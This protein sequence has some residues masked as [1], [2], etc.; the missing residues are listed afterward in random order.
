MSGD[1]Q[2]SDVGTALPEPLV[3]RAVD[4]GGRPVPEVAILF[5]L[6]E[7]D[8]RLTGADDATASA[9]YSTATGASGEAWSELMLGSEPGEHRVL[10]TAT[11]FDQAVEFHAT[12]LAPAEPV[13]SGDYALRF[14][15]AQGQEVLLPVV[16]TPGDQYTVEAWV[17][18]AASAAYQSVVGNN[19]NATDA[20]GSLDMVGGRLRMIITPRGGAIHE[21]RGVTVLPLGIWIHVAGVYDGAHMRLYVNGELDGELPLRGPITSD[22]LGRGTVIGGYAGWNSDE[23]SGWMTGLID[24]VR[25]WEVARTPEQLMADMRRPVEAQ[26]GLIGYWPLDDGQ[27]L[28]A[29][30]RSGRGQDGTLGNHRGSGR[31][32]W[33]PGVFHELGSL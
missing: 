15:G 32:Q 21:L 16:A 26:P 8:G 33:V 27:G 30:D 9:I 24:E 10:A 20:K 1:G 28:V 13:E 11:G 4:P 31:P 12:A 17:N 6:I 5:Q 23:G 22:H 14:T 3:V 19:A 2:A 7:G 18:L 29:V 25:I